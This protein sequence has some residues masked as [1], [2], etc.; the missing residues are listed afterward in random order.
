[1]LTHYWVDNRDKKAEAQMV[2]AFLLPPVLAGRP[3]YCFVASISFE[4]FVVG[5][6]IGGAVLI[7]GELAVNL[8]GFS[9][10]NLLSNF[11][12]YCTAKAG[13]QISSLSK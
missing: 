3:C 1:M 2:L 5:L 11:Q 6:A 9:Q 12:R 4:G 7:G 8:L 10:W 13:S